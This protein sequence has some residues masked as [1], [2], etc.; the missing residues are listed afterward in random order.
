MNFKAGDK[1]VVV[2]PTEGLPIFKVSGTIYTVT[3]VQDFKSGYQMLALEGM[4]GV[5]EG[6][7]FD[8]YETK[9]V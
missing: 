4:K 1:V 8:K 9:A 7:R 2:R 6:I 5:F 3:N